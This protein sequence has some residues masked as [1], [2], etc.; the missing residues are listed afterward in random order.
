[1]GA[2]GIEPTQKCPQNQA[3]GLQ[4][5]VKSG[6]AESEWAQLELL[7]MCLPA[8]ARTAILSLARA[9]VHRE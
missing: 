9:T 6:A 7:W 4:G 1:M 3:I 5:G 2:E 8:I